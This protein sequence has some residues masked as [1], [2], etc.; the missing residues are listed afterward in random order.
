MDLRVNLLVRETFH[1]SLFLTEHL[2]EALGLSSEDA[3]S[4]VSRFRDYDE[5]LLESQHAIY[6]D[7]AKLIQT[8]RDAAEELRLIF[9]HDHLAAESAEEAAEA[10]ADPPGDDAPSASANAAN[11]SLE[12]SLDVA[13]EELVE[14][15]S[16]ESKNLAKRERS[17]S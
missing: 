14:E 8:A 13:V 1:S 5:R 6:E 4:T 7:E 9:E 11:E 12:E 3:K 2:L 10:A 16:G 15:V 17:E